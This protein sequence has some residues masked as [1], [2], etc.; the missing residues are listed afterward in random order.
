[1]PLLVIS[2]RAWWSPVSPVAAA[3]VLTSAD[4]AAVRFPVLLVCAA[5]YGIAL[6]WA[7]VRTAARVAE[8]QLPE[9]CQIAVHSMA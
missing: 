9:L 7:G 8:P 3:E 5:C 4:P 2:N 6:A 1:M